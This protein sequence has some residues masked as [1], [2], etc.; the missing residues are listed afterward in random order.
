MKTLNRH[1]VRDNDFTIL[2][3]KPFKGLICTLAFSV[4]A[5]CGQRSSSNDTS[6]LDF[7]KSRPNTQRYAYLEAKDTQDVFLFGGSVIKT[8]GFTSSGLNMVLRPRKVK[9]QAAGSALTGR[10]LNVVDASSNSKILTFNLKKTGTNLEVDFASAGNDVQFR[11][12]IDQV[13]GRFT[14]QS[15]DGFWVSSGAPTVLN[16]SQDADTMVVD[17]EHTVRQARTESNGLGQF[18]VTEILSEAPGTVVVRIYLKRQKSLPQLGT[19]SRTVALGKSLQMGF[20]GSDFVGESDA[21]PIQRFNLGDAKQTAPK[22]TYYLK[23]VP[24]EFVETAKS[25]ILSWNEAFGADVI[26]VKIAPAGVDVGDPRFHVVKW[27][28]GTDDSLSW[29]GVAKMI[30]DP[31]SGL[32]MSG[33]LYIQGDTLIKLYKD[34]VGFSERIVAK[35]SVLSGQ[36]GGTTFSQD[37]GEQPAAPFL[38]DTKKSFEQYM[39]DYY[40]ETVAHEVGH[41]LGLRHNFKASTA[42]VDGKTGSVMD[43]APRAERDNRNGLGF[44][45]IAAIRWGYFG[46]LPDQELPF[47]TDDDIWKEYNCNQGDWG[48]PVENTVK[49][50]V[51]GTNLLASKAIAISRP[52]QISSMGGAIE[53]ALKIKKLQAQ[54]NPDVREASVASINSA[55]Q[56]I[57]TAKP[58]AGLSS[59]EQTIVL[60][61]LQA[62]RDL[63]V[64]TEQKL[65][66]DGKL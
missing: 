42:Q 4:L 6:E 58:I 48:H 60:K 64:K 25:A 59:A 46:E 40:H 31:D 11:Q 54:L 33:S 49:G 30:V 13:G 51:E 29:A 7:V 14:A 43:Y 9:L 44:Y 26:D 21:V 22:V 38:T 55:L 12:V 20:F 34:V 8:S 62:L 50:I 5:S 52:E 41:T 23:D 17:L 27:F 35:P 32:V 24:A 61:N 66:A 53:N 56:G 28:D 39:Q 19:T 63:A 65:K 18:R 37:M 36:I 1:Q 45:D 2:K 10:K 16:V 3:S 15:N 47:C 57:V